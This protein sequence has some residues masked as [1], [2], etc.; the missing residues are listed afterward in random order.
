LSLGYAYAALILSF[1]GGMWWG[2]AARQ[3]ERCPPWIW[4]AAVAPS[5]VAFA[6]A[7]P[8]AVGG[9]WPGPSLVILGIAL[10]LSL[11]VDRRLVSLGIAPDWWMGLRVPLSLGLGSLTIIAAFL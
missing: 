10:I 6:T 8:W 9:A 4:W 5:L 3:A 11:L 7:F 1:L 2:L